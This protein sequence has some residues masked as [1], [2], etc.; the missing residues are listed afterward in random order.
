MIKFVV[1]IDEVGRGPIA[2]PLTFCA[3]KIRHGENMRH[4]Q[5]SKDSKKLTFKQREEWFKKIKDKREEGVLDFSLSQI[6]PS[7]LDKIGL[8]RAITLSI[9]A[10]LSRLSVLPQDC[11]VL[12]DG[13]LKAPSKFKNQKTIIK[14]DEKIKVIGLASIVAKVTRDN[15]MIAFSKKYPRYGFEKHKG[16]GT[17]EHYRN[18]KKFGLC[19]IHRKSFLKS[20]K[21]VTYNV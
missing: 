9:S 10:C 13:G 14:G 8:S 21:S 7:V 16:Y 5:G 12:L 18:I 17:R 6:N 11:L 2:G 3:L 1:G 20:M 15:M 19:S 4:F